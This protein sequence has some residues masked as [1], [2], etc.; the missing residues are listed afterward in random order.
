MTVVLIAVAGLACALV[1]YL[2]VRSAFVVVQVR[3]DSMLPALKAH[4]RVLVSRVMR[5]RLRTGSII[6]LRSPLDPLPQARWPF[7]PP[8]SQ[9]PWV[10]KRIAA[11]PGDVVPARMS[12]A[13]G[14]TKTVPQGKLLVAADNATGHDSRE[15]G[16][17]ASKLVLGQ[18]IKTLWSDPQE[19]APGSDTNVVS[20]LTTGANPRWK[21]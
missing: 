12:R 9:T 19:A 20:S 1:L 16:F 15:W 10:I 8:L 6:V 21:A 11:L 2:A 13:T 18:V 17:V 14:K 7:A 3:G 5:N 4:D